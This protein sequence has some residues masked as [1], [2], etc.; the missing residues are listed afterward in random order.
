MAAGT[1]AGHPVPADPRRMSDMPNPVVHFEIGAQDAAKLR[2]FY[3][4]LFG[5]QFDLSDPGYGSIAETDDGIGGGIMQI[6]ETMAPYVTIYVAVD[7][8]GA[9]LDRVRELG[10]AEVVP[11]TPIPHTGEF[12]MFRDPQGHLIGLFSVEHA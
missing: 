5:W 8:L 9:T 11:P 3:R 2:A 7:D 6:R 4:D 12:A 1:T 10:G